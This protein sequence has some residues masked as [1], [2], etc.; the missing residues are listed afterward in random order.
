MLFRSFRWIVL[1]SFYFMFFALFAIAFSNS[2]KDKLKREYS[3]HKV[4]SY[5]TARVYMYN[6]VDCTDNQMFLIYSGTTYPWTCGRTNK[7]SSTAINAEHSVPQSFFG[8]KSPMVSDLHHIYPA[9]A[10]INSIRSNFRYTEVDYSQCKKFCRDMNCQT[11]RPSSNID[12]YSCLTVDN[13]FMPRKA[14]RG[15]VARGVLYFYTIY[16]SYDI[17]RVGSVSLFRRWNTQFPPNAQEKTRNDRLNK[18]QGNRNPYVDD[19]TL[20]DQAFA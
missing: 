12:D 8:K 19:Y 15:Q 11:E 2:V 4:Y 14:D 6:D 16:D 20:V 3:A 5:N 9:S 10:K 17:T 18:T 13:E 1:L 7:P